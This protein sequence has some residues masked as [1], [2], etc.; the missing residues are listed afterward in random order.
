M[1]EFRNLDRIVLGR[2]LQ[3]LCE[4]KDIAQ[5]DLA[6]RIAIKQSQVS[7]ILKG[8]GIPRLDTLLSISRVLGLNLSDVTGAYEG[9]LKCTKE[10]LQKEYPDIYKRIEANEEAHRIDCIAIKASLDWSLYMV[11]KDWDGAL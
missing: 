3:F 2:V 9:V 8:T 7:R 4:L 10:R 5:I 1:N 11:F 6:K